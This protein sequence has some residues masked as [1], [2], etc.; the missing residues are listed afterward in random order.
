MLADTAERERERG[1]GWKSSLERRLRGRETGHGGKNH[2][3][4]FVFVCGVLKWDNWARPN[5]HFPELVGAA[6]GPP[7]MSFA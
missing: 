5:G 2:W 4:H 6:V 3:V 1:A 7:L